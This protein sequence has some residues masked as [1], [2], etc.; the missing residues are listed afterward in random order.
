MSRSV[1]DEVSD[2]YLTNL[3]LDW[4]IVKGLTYRANGS[5]SYRNNQKDSYLYRDHTTGKDTNGK[6]T[7]KNVLRTEYLFE[8]ILNYNKEFNKIHRLGITLMQSVNVL[9]RTCELHINGSL[10]F[11]CLFTCGWFICIWER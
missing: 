6:A 4:E 1:N 2:N 7:I 11:F 8:N 10:Y 3:Y 9:F 5:M